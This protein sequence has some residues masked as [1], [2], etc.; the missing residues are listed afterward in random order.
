MA[1]PCAADLNRRIKIEKLTQ[2]KDAQ[3]G[4]VDTWALQFPVWAK[5]MHLSGNDK[6]LTD[7]GG[8]V[9]EARTEFTARYK[10]G[11]NASQY[12]VVYDEKIYNIKHVNDWNEEHEWMILTC[13]TGL[14]DGR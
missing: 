5:V 9:A 6:R 4:M 14:N 2:S 11:V 10:R 8:K 3:G 13:D 12:R 7:Q 1:K